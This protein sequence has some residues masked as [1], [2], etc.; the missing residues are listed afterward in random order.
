MQSASP[1]TANHDA[2]NASDLAALVR[3]QAETIAELKHRLVWFERQLFGQ[4]SERLKLLQNPQQMVLGEVA[5][6]AAGPV[7]EG[8]VVA[9]H[10]RRPARRDLAADVGEAESVPFFDASRVP[11]E[12]IQLLPP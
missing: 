5:A 1:T 9:A 8:K 6:G 12:V 11:V 2:V 3:S 10:V 4:K 7:P